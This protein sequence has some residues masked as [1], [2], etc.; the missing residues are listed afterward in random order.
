MRFRLS[1]AKNKILKILN[2]ILQRS[3]PDQLHKHNLESVG[4]YEK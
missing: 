4:R 2:T 1:L 3:V